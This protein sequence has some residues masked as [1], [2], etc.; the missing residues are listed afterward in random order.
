M[1]NFD[2]KHEVDDFFAW[3]AFLIL[4]SMSDNASLKAIPSPPYQ[5]DFT[6]PGKSPVIDSSLILILDKPNFL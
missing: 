5:L 4:A 2:L 3:W 6:T 1:F